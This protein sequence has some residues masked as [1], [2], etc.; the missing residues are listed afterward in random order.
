MKSIKELL[1]PEEVELAQASNTAHTGAINETRVVSQLY[2]AMRQ[3][4]MADD[5][6]AANNE[7]RESQRKMADDMI[8]VNKDLAAAKADMNKV[9][10]ENGDLTKFTE[11]YDRYCHLLDK[12][13]GLVD[14]R[15]GWLLVSQSILFAALGLSSAGMSELLTK[16]VPWVGIGSAT[17]IGLS[18][19][20]AVGTFLRLRKTM[21]DACPPS[22][23]QDQSFPQLHRHMPII[24]LGFLA[25][26]ALPL[27]FCVAWIA[28]IVITS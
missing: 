23:D 18:V 27:T 17:L 25:P 6:I 22:Q 19:L 20:A 15:I 1:T 28:V 10:T 8:Q 2:V 24:V 3:R 7:L 26:L 14:Q 5:M 4:E 9:E 16:V 12:E 13:D 11:R 21:F